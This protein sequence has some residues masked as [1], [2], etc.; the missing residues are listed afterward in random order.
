MS[1]AFCRRP[2]GNHTGETAVVWA[3]SYDE[4]SVPVPRLRGFRNSIGV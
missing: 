4:K 1:A 3:D 2:N